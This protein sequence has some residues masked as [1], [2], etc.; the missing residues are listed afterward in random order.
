MSYTIESYFIVLS[1]SLQ[2]NDQRWNNFLIS[3][4]EYPNFSICIRK[5][6]RF[7]KGCKWNNFFYFKLKAPQAFRWYIKTETVSE[8]SNFSWRKED[9]RQNNPSLSS[10]VQRACLPP[11]FYSYNQIQCWFKLS[12][13][14]E[15]NL[16]FQTRFSQIGLRLDKKWR[17]QKL[18][19]ISPELIWCHFSPKFSTNIL[20]QKWVILAFFN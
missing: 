16:N 12:G 13:R 18:L 15:Q 20:P 14:N 5:W 6:S 19:R 7:Q 17:G 1:F 8:K 9:P 10:D 11:D 2:K 3:R 4:N